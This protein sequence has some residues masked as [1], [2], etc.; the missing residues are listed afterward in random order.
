[1]WPKKHQE[2]PEQ[3]PHGLIAYC[4]RDCAR[5]DVFLAGRTRDKNVRVQAARE[6]SDLLNRDIGPGQIRCSG[7][8]SR[9]PYFVYCTQVCKVRELGL[10]WQ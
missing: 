7:C 5:C 2:I 8:R 4:G 10:K 9:G 3:P 6:W 1:M